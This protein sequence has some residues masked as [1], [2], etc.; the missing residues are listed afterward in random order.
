MYLQAGGGLKFEVLRKQL[1]GANM[2]PLNPDLTAPK[3][4]IKV[5]SHSLEMA[6]TTYMMNDGQE[7]ER[8]RS[9]E[10]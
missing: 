7:K 8:S 6:I 1:I 4:H 3:Y 5:K 9:G 10:E 2:I